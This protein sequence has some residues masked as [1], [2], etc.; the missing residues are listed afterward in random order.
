[1]I[2]PPYPALT[3]LTTLNTLSP[4]QQQL[5][6]A[7]SIGSVEELAGTMQADPQALQRLLGLEYPAFIALRCEVEDVLSR[8][9]ELRAEFERQRTR[10]YPMGALN[11]DTD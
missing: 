6:S 8:N 7:Y 10:S 4:A 2:M 5:L 1:M 3:R 9:P 11:P